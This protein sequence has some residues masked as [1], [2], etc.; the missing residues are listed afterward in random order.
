MARCDEGYRCVVCGLDVESITDSMLY[1]RYVLGEVPLERLHLERECHI[2]CNPAIS[3]YIVDP[4][5]P[6]VICEGSFN[7]DAC[8][9]EF[10]HTE[11]DRVTAGWRRLQTI[12]TLGISVVEY[13]LTSHQ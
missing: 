13:P 7:K 9:S 10:V 8:D 5:F 1:L 6:P 3:Q 4:D 11:E 2:R 12:P